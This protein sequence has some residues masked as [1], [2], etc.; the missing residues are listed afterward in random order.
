[1][2]PTMSTSRDHNYCEDFQQTVQANSSQNSANKNLK[3]K[4]DFQGSKPSKKNIISSRRVQGN[5]LIKLSSETLL[6]LE[7]IN[8][9]TKNMAQ[10]LEN[11]N[12]NTESIAHSM[13][14]LANIAN[15]YFK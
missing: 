1:M 12:K 5:E 10:S 3:R 9:N 2:T 8:E 13:S 4:L 15:R 14:I 11:L 6:S 7:Q